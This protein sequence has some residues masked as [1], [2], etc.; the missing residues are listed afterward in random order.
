MN[1]GLARGWLAWHGVWSEQMRKKNLLKQA[2]ARLTRPKLLASYGLWRRDWQLTMAA[3]STLTQEQRL[4]AEAEDRAKMIGEMQVQINKLIKELDEASAAMLSGSGREAELKRLMEEEL[5]REKEKRIAG[6]QQ[7]GMKRLMNQGLARGWSA[8]HGMWSEKVRKKNMLKQAGARLTKPKL[9]A[10]YTHWRRDWDADRAANATLTVTER[11]AREIE[12]SR[13]MISKLQ[14][15]VAVQMSE[16]VEARAAMLSGTGREAELKRLMEEE[17]EREKEKRIA[18]L[19]QQGM[20]RLMNQGLAR[21]WSAWH[22]MWSEKVRKKNMLKQAGTRL[23]KPKLAA[24]YMLWRRDWQIEITAQGMMTEAQKLEAEKEKSRKL[25]VDLTQ[26]RAELVEARAS[27][28]SGSGREAELKRLMEEELEREKEKRVAALQQQGMKRLMNQGLA[29]GWSAWH[30]MWSEKVRKKNMLKQ[31][32]AR[33]TKPKLAAAYGHWKRDW[34]LD[35]ALNASMTQEQR[36]AAEIAT[37]QTVE[38]L[39]LEL[40]QELEKAR[41]AMLTGKGLEVEMQRRMQEE[42][43]REKEKRVAALQQQGMKRLMNQGLARGWTAWHGMWEEKVR[44]RNLLKQA[45]ARLTKPKLIQSYTHWRRDWEYEVAVNGLLTAEQKAALEREERD[46]MQADLQK[47]YERVC[48]ELEDARSSMLAGNGREAELK[49]LMEEELEREKEKRVAGLQQQGMKRLMNQG[50]ARGWSAW[51][52]MWSEKVRKKNMLKQA[53]ARLIKPKLAAAYKH[54][55][56]DWEIVLGA[57]AHMTQEQRILA[58]AE[59]RTR[60]MNEMQAELNKVTKELAAAREAIAS[61]NADEYERM[62]AMQEELEREKEKRVAALQQQG[63]KRLMNQGLARGWSAWQGMWDEKVRK[64]NLLK[65]AGA[66]LTKPKLVKSY[67]HWRRDWETDM[68]ASST[69]TTAQKLAAETDEKQKLLVEVDELK[70]SLAEARDLMASGKGQEAELRRRMEEELEREKEK[71]VAALQQQGLKRLMN[72]GLARGWTAWYGKYDEA[73]RKKNLLKQAGARLIKPKLISSYTHWR[74]DWEIEMG[75]SATMTQEQRLVAALEDAQRLESE[76]AHTRKELDATRAAALAGTAMEAEL[77]RQMEEELEREREK[78]IAGLQQQGVKRL[79]NQGLAR[80]WSAWHDMWADKVR[81]RNL[82]K[83]AGM[84]LTKP[85]LTAAYKHWMLDWDAVYAAQRAEEARLASMTVEQRLAE[86]TVKRENTESMLK[87]VE[88]QLKEAYEAIKNGSGKELEMKRLMEEELER[89]REKRVAHLQQMGMK[90]LM[91]QGL[92]RG[93][94]A[95]HDK[96][97]EHVRKRN[98]LKQ[99]GARLMKPKLVKSYGHWRRGWEI[100]VAEGKTMTSEQKLSKQAEDMKS[101][102]VELTKVRNELAE[103]RKSMLHGNGR[104]AELKRLM[105]EELER[106]REKRVAA[107]QQQGMKRLMNQGLARGWSAW[108][109]MWEEKV[110]QRNLLKQAGARLLK[111]KLIAS[112][113][114]WRRGW[115][116]E[117]AENVTMSQEDRLQREISNGEALQRQ[118]DKLNM[119]LKKAHEALLGGGGIE[120]QM[121]AQIEIELEKE[122]EKRVAH[123]QQMGVKRL[124]N[125]NLA[126]GWSAWHD[127][128][129]EAVRKR[130]LLKQAGARLTRPKLMAAYQHWTRDWDLEAAKRSKM[131]V[132]ERAAAERAENESERQALISKVDELSKQLDEARKAMLTGTGR[133]AELKRLMEE[134]L[135]RKKEKRVAALQQ[136]GLKRLMNQGLARGWTAWHGKYADYV[137]KRNLLKQAGAR[138]M[139]PKL[140]KG[141]AHWRR[142]WEIEMA[143]ILNMTAEQ[144]VAAEAEQRQQMLLENAS[145]KRQLEEARLSMLSGSGREAELKRLMEEE[146]EREREKRVAALQQQGVKRLMNQGLARG[147]TA[148]HSKWA[149]KVRKRN[150]LKQAGARLL[151]PKLAAAYKQWMA[152][153]DAD[154]A[155]QRDEERRLASMSV[156]ERLAEQI[157]KTKSLETL[158]AHLQ[159]ELQESRLAML[160]G[161]GE[162]VEKSRLLALQLEEEKYKRVEHLQSVGVRRMLKQGLAR[163]WTAWHDKYSEV[164]RKR[165]LLKQAGARLMKPKLIAGYTHWRRGWEIEMWKNNTMSNEQ[166]SAMERAERDALE[167]QLMRDL[168]KT[169]KELKEAR[170]AI[171]QG[172]G[173]EFEMQR[174]MQEEL[175]RE[176]EKRVAALQQQGVKRLMNQGLARGWTAWHGKYAELVRKRNLLKQ[177]G[178]R[179]L[180]PKLVKSFTHWRRDWDLTMASSMTM[181]T[182]EKLATAVS[183]QKQLAHQVSLLQEELANARAAMLSG[184]GREA[185]IKRLMEEELEREREKRVAA[186]QQ[187]GVKR[188]M[189]Q[190]LARG[191]TA[192]HDMYAESVRKRNLLK[193]A[194]ARLLKPKL[195]AA[196]RH[197]MRDWDAAFAAQ[198]AKELAMASMTMEERLVMESNRASVAEQTVETLEQQLA[199]AREAMINGT[200]REMELERRMQEELER[201]K[202]KRIAGL[203]QQGMKRLMNQGLARGWSAWHSKWSEK[204]RKRNL[205]KKSGTMLM[206]PKLVRGFTHW[207]RDWDIERV[208]HRTMTKEQQLAKEIEERQAAYE[209]LERE[210]SETRKALEDALAGPDL[211]K[212]LERERERRVEQLQQMGVKRLMNRELALGWSAWH[213][214]Y[215]EYKHR[216]RLVRHALLRITKPKLSKAY[217]HWRRDLDFAMIEKE[218]LKMLKE[219]D[220][221]KGEAERIL[222]AVEEETKLRTK[223]EVERRER[224]EAELARKQMEWEEELALTNIAL[225]EARK[226]ATDALKR[227]SVERAAADEA[228]KALEEAADADRQWIAE[229]AKREE[230]EA[231]YRMLRSTKEEEIALQHV[232]LVEAR[233]AATDALNRLTMEQAT[234]EATKKSTVAMSDELKRALRSEQIAVQEAERLNSQLL[235]F[236]DK[237]EE[238]LNRLLEE[239]RDHLTRDILRITEDYERQLAEMRVQVAR[240]S[241]INEASRAARQVSPSKLRSLSLDWDPDKSLAEMLRDAIK[242]NGLRVQDFFKELDHDHD[243]YVSLTEWQA[244]FKRITADIPESVLEKAYDECNADSS[245]SIEF[246]EFDGFV[247]GTTSRP[248]SASTNKPSMAVAARK[249]KE[250][251]KKSPKDMKRSRQNNMLTALA[252][253]MGV[254]PEKQWFEEAESANVVGKGEEDFQDIMRE[255]ASA[256]GHA[257]LDNDGMLD[258]DE[259]CAMVKYRE[260]T[261]YTE[262]QLREKFKELDDDGSGK[263]DLP[264]FIAYSLRDSLRKSKGRAIDLFRVWDEDDSGYIDKNEFG[265]AIVALGFVAGRED[266]GKVFDMLDE[267]GSGEIE[268]KELAQILKA[269]PAAAAPL[270]PPST[271]KKGSAKGPSPTVK[272]K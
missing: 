107:L 159:K 270:P 54:W 261:K 119:D 160:S 217:A 113:T 206:K 158:N 46:R 66:R 126:R 73:V 157:G 91:N 26:L 148:W 56:K 256:F 266:I 76:L 81:K 143:S 228:R 255:R 154:L 47:N 242:K 162:E 260:T 170:D 156:E 232:A 103:A 191:W 23:T 167:Q 122:R 183:E 188:L 42:L 94:S 105:E 133:E 136:Q 225:V 234:N 263:V 267:D 82:L 155:L 199:E 71:R 16:L 50:L 258:F 7:Q 190:G 84:R 29:R 257:D 141:Y 9:A 145:L 83:Q 272:K 60:I 109:G 216:Q 227:V 229:M 55:M 165:N 19:Q 110:R 152:D 236:Q 72:Q 251:K 33:L 168:D 15:Q 215:A 98:L 241:A 24:A 209:Q 27:M 120:A 144:R 185:E 45:G 246:S 262:A 203:Q 63:V 233:K 177:A 20:K 180:K 197:W 235:D 205:L 212:Q 10:C 198:K 92:A 114:H 53:G 161:R 96:W 132:A 194:G 211:A 213:S 69:M 8:W 224:A 138:L 123:L 49:R 252:S 149:E 85:K 130:N 134:E 75:R 28:L 57:Q 179:L 135:E 187:Q 34:D 248:S 240:T 86:E 70:K 43:E 102:E 59:E 93:W 36:L 166:R 118:I 193:Q 17:L 139:K 264:E 202:E 112:Y 97:S 64:K 116:I 5:E 259:F 271:G 61:G 186:L 269:K 151:K 78:R 214:M 106:E 169:R 31:A 244:G 58:E 146:L 268:Y 222:A 220:K 108:H 164:I 243:G 230:T 245:E 101:L 38:A 1:Q 22:G 172:R 182:E 254:R 65:Q 13:Q 175:E 88:K 181:S 87:H 196:Y 189:N 173:Q 48:Q 239:H 117:M 171:M 40:T 2:G 67:A 150:L 62:R 231:E 32:G 221:R 147:W 226:A 11:M 204:V 77:K 192:W 201:E 4:A 178:A 128:Y 21:G 223:R 14:Q 115:E 12:E 137:R 127:K 104:E 79:M 121:Q 140:A 125:Q 250:D 35:V 68:A 100:D 195:V 89:E 90:R 95:W 80:G 174:R 247:K 3:R 37:R 131:T 238:K 153:W 99:S 207:L 111:P 249:V 200:G 25:E 176:K 208:K 6:L 39:N 265:K 218:R 124:I 210:L 142:D 18:G 163:G 129:A 52:G 41:A 30:G 237:S 51:H 219:E 184:N 44:Q 74:R 253:S